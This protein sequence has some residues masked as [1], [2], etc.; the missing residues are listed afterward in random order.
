MVKETDTSSY[1]LFREGLSV[2]YIHRPVLI[3]RLYES[4]DLLSNFYHRK[5][6]T[7]LEGRIALL[8]SCGIIS[9]FH[10]REYICFRCCEGRLV[11]VVINLV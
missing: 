4:N 9:F 6:F 2:P 5:P 8:Q 3:K 1:L 10:T 11:A 7:F